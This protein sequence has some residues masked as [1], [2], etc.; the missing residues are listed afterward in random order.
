MKK[1]IVSGFLFIFLAG[2]CNPGGSVESKVNKLIKDRQFRKAESLILE[3]E[4]TSGLSPKYKIL[5]ARVYFA[6]GKYT[7]ALKTLYS[8][9]KDIY[10]KTKKNYINLL[11]EIAD[12]AYSKGEKRIA[13]YALEKVVQFDPFYNIGSRFKILGDYY[14]SKGNCKKA[15]EYYENYLS[16]AGGDLQ[17]IAAP[18]AKCLYEEGRYTDVLEVINAADPK[19][20]ERDWIYGNSLFQIGKMFYESEIYD[21]AIVYF[22][23]VLDFDKPYTIMD[24]ALFYLGLSYE[25]LGEFDK[26]IETYEKLIVF[27]KRSPYAARARDRLNIL[28]R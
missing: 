9:N 21:S 18:Y 20:A 27:Y 15:V 24:D 22:K 16:M 8:M 10:G 19:F 1:L 17:E 6:W 2:A 11:L 12:S 23:R 14:Y 25:Q 7:K 13:I 5:L 4:E 26:A 3:Q 28:T